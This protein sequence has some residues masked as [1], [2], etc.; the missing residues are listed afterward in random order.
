MQNQT[1]HRPSRQKCRT[2]EDAIQML[3]E[4]AGIDARVFAGGRSKS[5]RTKERAE[6]RENTAKKVGQNMRP[7]NVEQRKQGGAQKERGG[8]NG[9]MAERSVR[10]ERHP[11]KETTERTRH[12]G[13]GQEKEQEEQD[14]KDCRR[15]EE[16]DR[17]KEKE[18]EE[19][20]KK[21]EKD[22]I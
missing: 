3:E 21:E 7:D 2:D 13:T 5:K 1:N 10:R 16:Q 15:Q 17:K 22:K 14:K 9:N 8:T 20:R 12:K 18:Q 11:R 19:Q 6:G 4:G